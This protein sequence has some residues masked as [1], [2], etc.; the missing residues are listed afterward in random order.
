MDKES[1]RK[2]KIIIGDHKRWRETS[3]NP[4]SSGV[5]IGID[6]LFKRPLFRGGLMGRIASWFPVNLTKCENCDSMVSD[7]A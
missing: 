5:L 1:N 4:K 3:I 2:G 7:V 6:F